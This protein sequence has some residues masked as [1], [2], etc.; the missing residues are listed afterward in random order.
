MDTAPF[1]NKG[2]S[3][4]VEIW[5]GL[6][7]SRSVLYEDWKI[8]VGKKNTGS[9]LSILLASFLSQSGFQLVVFILILPTCR[10]KM[11]S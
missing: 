8:I 9:E 7:C 11:S 2:I 5:S 1:A 3:D 4:I 10:R 6:I